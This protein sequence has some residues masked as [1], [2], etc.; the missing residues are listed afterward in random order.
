MKQNPFKIVFLGLTITSS[1]R[2]V[3]AS[4]Y[5]GLMYELVRR[6]HEVLFLERAIPLYQRH[7]DLTRSPFFQIETYQDPD[8]LR[9]QFGSNIRE[10]DIIIIGSGIPN[11]IEIA[12]WILV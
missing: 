11:G 7:Q 4:T 9:K 3:H 8:D 2:N 1:W 12:E 10:A 6:G 5:R